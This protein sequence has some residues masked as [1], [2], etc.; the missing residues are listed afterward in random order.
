MVNTYGIQRMWVF[1]EDKELSLRAVKYLEE[2]ELTT[3]ESAFEEILKLARQGKI[4]V[5][6]GGI[7]PDDLDIPLLRPEVKLWD[8]D[9]LVEYYITKRGVII[10]KQ[11]QKE[12]ALSE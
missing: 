9:D 2:G 11:C 4:E 1:I 8:D 6:S 5:R 3:N 12:T 10:L 7:V